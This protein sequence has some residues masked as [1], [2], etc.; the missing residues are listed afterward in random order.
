[1]NDT[2][3]LEEPK[4]T[5]AIKNHRAEFVKA[6]GDVDRQMEVIKDFIDNVLTAFEDYAVYPN[7]KVPALLKPGAEKLGQMFGYYTI[8]EIHLVEHDW[9]KKITGQKWDKTKSSYVPNET[10]GFVSYVILTK[11]FNKE[12]NQPVGGGV[13]QASSAEHQFA[14]ANAAVSSN[15]VLKIAKKRS[16]VDAILNCSLVSGQFTQDLEDITFGK[17]SAKSSGSST[18]K[19][20]YSNSGSSASPS[21][22]GGK[23]WSLETKLKFGR[24]MGKC[25]PEVPHE[26][27]DYYVNKAYESITNGDTYANY[28]KQF[29]NVLFKY[30]RENDFPYNVE[31]Y[32][33]ISEQ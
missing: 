4:K 1:M 24:Q 33:A 7:S 27:W 12:N 22:G 26:E 18:T 14:Y 29:L 25:I 2:L 9:D 21:S 17:D 30:L 3:D 16:F 32:E 28:N 15:T 5:P 6:D 11:L 23:G 10:I 31:I 8:P 13:G 20:A 19:P